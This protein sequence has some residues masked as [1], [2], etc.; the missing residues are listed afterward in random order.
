[1]GTT[2][3]RCSQTTAQWNKYWADRL[4]GLRERLL[5]ELRKYEAKHRDPWLTFQKKSPEAGSADLRLLMGQVAGLGAHLQQYR[6]RLAAQFCLPKEMYDI[7]VM[8]KQQRQQQQQ[9]QQ[10]Q[11]PTAESASG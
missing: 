5:E 10:P 6:P 7:E 3:Q 2:L 8:P 11:Q 4:V 1:M 9:Q